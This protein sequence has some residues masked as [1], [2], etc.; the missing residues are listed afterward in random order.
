MNTICM[1]SSS[2]LEDQFNIYWTRHKIQYS[3]LL[4]RIICVLQNEFDD[5][6]QLIQKLSFLLNSTH[7]KLSD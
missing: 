1:N 2:Y 7:L 4:S 6:F 3:V 5:T